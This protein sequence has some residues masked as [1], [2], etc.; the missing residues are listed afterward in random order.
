MRGKLSPWRFVAIVVP[1]PVIAPLGV[2]LLGSVLVPPDMHRIPLSLGLV[3]G[4]PILL[5]VALTWLL[6]CAFGGQSGDA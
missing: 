2:L 5:A 3:L 6:A 4:S 1:G